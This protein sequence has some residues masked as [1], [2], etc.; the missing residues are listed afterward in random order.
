MESWSTGIGLHFGGDP[1]AEIP[2]SGGLFFRDMFTGPSE[3]FVDAET[4]NALQRAFIESAAEVNEHQLIFG[5][6][7]G[8]FLD[9]GI[10]PRLGPELDDVLAGVLGLEGIAWHY[11]ENGCNSRAL[12]VN[13]YLGRLGIFASV[14]FAKGHF[15]TV[16]DGKRTGWLFHAAVGLF[17]D[18]DGDHRF[19]ILD[20]AFAN[21]PLS[22]AEWLE[23]FV[24]RIGTTPAGAGPRPQV[25]VDVLPGYQ[26]QP[27]GY[28]G[29]AELTLRPRALEQARHDM[30]L[31]LSR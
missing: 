25:A 9:Q 30:E 19:V 21:E 11:L 10:I 15:E 26:W 13:E 22:L 29:F 20:P 17:I 1:N 16:R 12:L 7:H 5:N 24:P 23:R 8:L 14:V 28:A 4:P 3:R 6:L 2:G 27:T 18:G 31:Y